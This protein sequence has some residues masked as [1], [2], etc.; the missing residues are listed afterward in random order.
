MIGICKLFQMVSRATVAAVVMLFLYC[1]KTLN[2]ESIV[3]VATP[4]NLTTHTFLNITG[5]QDKVEVNLLMT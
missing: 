4:S 3:L 1:R 2:C 5:W